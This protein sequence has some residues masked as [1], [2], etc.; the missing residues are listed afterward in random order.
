MTDNEGIWIGQDDTTYGPYA[1]ADVGQWLLE[2]KLDADALAWREGMADW[3]PLVSLMAMTP[4][5]RTTV[6]PPPITPSTSELPAS[7]GWSLPPGGVP[8]RLHDSPADSATSR[9]LLPEPPTLHWGLVLLFTVFT[10]GIFGMVWAFF[11]ARW[12]RLIDQRSRATVQLAIALTCL[13]VGYPLYLIGI[14]SAL[15][16]GQFGGTGTSMVSIG[17]MLLLAQWV[18][19]LV[20]FFS[21][22]SSVKR[23][24]AARG[25]TLEIGGVTLF[26]FRLYYLQA[27]L[28]WVGHWRHTGRTSPAPAKGVLWAVFLLLPFAIG[29]L[30]AVAIP[31]YQAYATRAHVADIA[32]PVDRA[33]PPVAMQ[34]Q[35][36]RVLPVNRSSAELAGRRWIGA[37]GVSRLDVAG[38]TITVAMENDRSHRQMR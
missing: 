30:A 8:G 17:G 31:A 12:I 19:S 7:G 2:G 36:M 4:G 10:L 6:L 22:A 35:Q 9:A 15:G 38:S 27:V 33:M 20:A 16:S 32:L 28:S 29:L 34:N 26:F 11:Q 14:A 18:L 5:G 25:V 3:V 13:V 21:M 1:E 23:L 37:R 24:L